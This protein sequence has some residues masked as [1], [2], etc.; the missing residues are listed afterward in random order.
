MID[1]GRLQQRA[2]R[3]SF[4]AGLVILVFKFTAYSVTNS[5]AL[6]SDAMESII[7]VIASSFAMWSIHLAK[8]PPDANHPYG[9]GK[10]EYFSALFEGVLIIVAAGCVLYASVP[11]VLAPQELT[12]LDY[13]LLVSVLASAMNLA[14]GLYLMRQGRRTRSITLVAD[15]KHVLAD[16][17][18]TAGV[19]VGLGGVLLT[20]WLWLDGFIACV[21]AV[22]ILWT[23]YGLVREAVKGLMNETDE[24]LVREI[25]ELLNEARIPEWISIHKLRA[26]KAG[27]FIHVDFHLVLPMQLSLEE[28]RRIV[29]DVESLFEKRFD[30]IAEIM[31]RADVCTDEQLCRVCTYDKCKNHIRGARPERW[32]ERSLCAGGR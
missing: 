18:T 27:R 7:N 23:G 12:R 28:A 16:V 11:R 4:V 31:V 15:G 9:H 3:I 17:Y 1:S 8:S 30:G 6:L 22:N 13:G 32:T 24:D 5:A 10:V 20:G 29:G 14:L 25:C 19:L 26:W 21:V 2:I